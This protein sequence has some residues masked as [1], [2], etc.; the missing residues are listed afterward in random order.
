MKSICFFFILF[1]EKFTLIL[2]IES[3]CSTV[4]IFHTSFTPQTVFAH[5][6]TF[7]IDIMQTGV[8]QKLLRSVYLGEVTSFGKKKKQNKHSATLLSSLA[9]MLE[10]FMERQECLYC[11]KI[12]WPY[13]TIHNNYRLKVTRQ[14]LVSFK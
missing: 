6:Y 3:V 8:L 9:V 1:E 13:I 11:C 2:P 10:L 4:L 14:N 7:L 12:I 5:I